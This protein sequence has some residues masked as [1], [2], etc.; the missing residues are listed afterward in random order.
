MNFWQR[1]V[2][3]KCRSKLND[4]GIQGHWMPIAFAR[5]KRP[6]MLCKCSR[7]LHGVTEDT[8]KTPVIVS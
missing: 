4:G 3:V 8:D 7:S 5:T 1:C 6:Q 2:A